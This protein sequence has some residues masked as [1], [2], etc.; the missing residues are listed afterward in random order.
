MRAVFL[1]NAEW[2]VPPLEALA[3]S[4]HRPALVVTRVPRPAG[5]GN[6]PRPTAVAE[7]ARALGLPLAEV[8]TVKQGPGIEAVAGAR[9][10]VLVVAAYGEILPQAVLD[11][12]SIAPVN[13]HFSWLPELR[14]AAPVQRAILAGLDE[15]GVTTIRM[16]AGMDAG[17]IL[18]QEREPIHPSDDAGSLGARLAERGG[19]LLV[20][21]L[22]RL[23]SGT[24][25]DVPQDGSKATYAPK[26]QRSDRVV[27]W[28]RPGSAVV[29]QIRALAPDPGAETVF[30]NRLLKVY[31]A[32]EA[33]RDQVPPGDVPP[34]EV[35]LTDPNGPVVA[36]GQ[37]PVVLVNVQPEGR[38]R[39]SGAEFVR[40]YRPRPGERLG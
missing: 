21:T 3:R 5:R 24:L 16:D 12:P 13:L 30:R 31:R 28:T 36:T 6:R 29:R 23:S 19:R 38:R 34:G 26:M 2:S 8:E 25:E 18:L 33:E 32:A 10:D 14:G 27:E 20:E 39:M 40:G 37:G 9:P 1:G 35:I 4:V 22:D 11:L 17:P 15:T 7:A